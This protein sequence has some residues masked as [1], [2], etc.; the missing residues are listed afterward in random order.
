MVAEV[1]HFRA[2]PLCELLQVD[3]VTLGVNTA[4]IQRGHSV[5][6]VSVALWAVH[7]ERSVT[8][9]RENE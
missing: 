7:A 5:P 1:E 6:H 3:D 4:F 2:R 9:R 8:R